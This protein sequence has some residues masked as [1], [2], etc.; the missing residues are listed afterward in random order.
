MKRL[1]C[2]L[3]LLT[4]CSCARSSP[5][6]KTEHWV[7]VGHAA[8]GIS[9]MSGADAAKWLGRSVDLG[10]DLA[11]AGPDSCNRPMYERGPAPGDSV[12]QA[13]NIAPGALGASLPP[14]ATVTLVETSCDGE[15]WYSPGALLIETSPTHAFTPW[16]GVFFELE[17]R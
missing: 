15:P 7:I 9:A 8:P 4:L 10:P 14:G 16:E 11:V 6:N 17:K 1:A 3:A 13:Y 5:E 12:L 2:A